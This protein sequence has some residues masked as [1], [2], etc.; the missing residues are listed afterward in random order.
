M[1][2]KSKEADKEYMREYYLSRREELL[3]KRQLNYDKEKNKAQH[4]RW[5]EKEGNREKWN[6]YMRERRRQAKLDGKANV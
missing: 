6:A 1:A 3:K 4:Y 5:L 2:R